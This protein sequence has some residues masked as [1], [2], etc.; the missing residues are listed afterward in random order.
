[1]KSDRITPG[2][3]W[4]V[5]WWRWSDVTALSSYVRP[6]KSVSLKALMNVEEGE[7]GKPVRP[8]IDKG[9]IR[10]VKDGEGLAGRG[11]WRKQKR[12]GNR[13]DRIAMSCDKIIRPKGSRLPAGL[14][15][16]EIHGTF[17]LQL[18]LGGGVT[19]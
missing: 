7:L 3:K 8:R 12:R 5:A 9:G 13:A 17:A 10:T 4:Q 1:M 6:G 11:C 15:E 16:G 2:P 14:D 18:T 19:H